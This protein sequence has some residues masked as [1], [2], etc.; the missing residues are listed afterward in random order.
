MP[1][2]IQ[3]QVGTTVTLHGLQ[4]RPEL[5]STLAS[6]IGPINAAGRYPVKLADGESILIKPQNLSVATTPIVAADVTQPTI[7]G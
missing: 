6:I 4:A 5:N 1:P 3:L 7:T 2:N